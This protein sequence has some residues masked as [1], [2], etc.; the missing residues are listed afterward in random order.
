LV[1]STQPLRSN[2]RASASSISKPMCRIAVSP[3][4]VSLIRSPVKDCQI[5][6]RYSDDTPGGPH[7]SWLSLKETGFPAPFEP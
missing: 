7:V 4:A 3:T 1:P 5:E 6:C 2:K